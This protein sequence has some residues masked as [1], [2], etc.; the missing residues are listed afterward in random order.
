M[1]YTGFQRPTEDASTTTLSPVQLV[2]S[3]EYGV[4]TPKLRK[5]F[6]SIRKLL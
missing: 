1:P 2:N 5:T 3:I 6:R 4:K